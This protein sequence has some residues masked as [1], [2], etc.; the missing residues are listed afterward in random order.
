[1][2]DRDTR[3][4]A[5]GRL[6]DGAV[7]DLTA[8]PRLDPAVRAG[9]RRRGA[10]LAA[11][12][13]VVVVFVAGLIWA[14]TQLG[15]ERSSMP[16]GSATPTPTVY[17]DDQHG[18]SVTVPTGWQVAAEPL[19][20]WVSD[21]HE[22][23]SMGTYALRPGGD[24]VIDA[25]VPSHAVEDM[26]P[27]DIFVWLNERTPPD[28]R[29]P[30]RPSE[31]SPEALCQSGSPAGGSRDC[32]PGLAQGI[33]GIR[34]W[35]TSFQDNGRGFYLFVGMG[36]QAYTDPARQQQAWDV[37]DS[38]SFDA[39]PTGDVFTA[40]PRTDDAIEPGDD[41]AATAEAA[42][43]AFVRASLT[44]DEATVGAYSDPVA[45]EN[46][47]D[48]TAAASTDPVLGSGSAASD[49]IASACGA[50][51]ANLSW[52]VTIDDGTDSASMD[53][54]LYLIRRADGWKVW[55]VY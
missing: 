21:P 45:T 18:L 31:F 33:E 37:L 44:G 53:F 25:Q 49:P 17:R 11:S 2:S 9:D 1:M 55:G 50:D 8:E 48:V 38:L 13:T 46:G 24:A 36:E 15:V 26:G 32:V 51:V 6:L 52:T 35:W 16:L 28:K 42:A 12:I 43:T 22:I 4:E 23:L 3:D 27:S 47:V 30:D 20:T 34:A 41:A 29:Q 10:R 40:C 19:N 5:L 7:R 14:A 39:A 54:A